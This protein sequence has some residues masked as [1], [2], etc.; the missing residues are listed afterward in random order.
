LRINVRSTAEF[1]KFAGKKI[2]S[3]L[4]KLEKKRKHLF[5]SQIVMAV[6]SILFFLGSFISF[7]LFIDDNRVNKLFFV[8]AFF[9]F[10]TSI[11][12][13]FTTKH[14]MDNYRKDYK[15]N[16]I[17]RI[18]SYISEN[19]DYYPHDHVPPVYFTMSGLLTKTP[20]RCQGEDLVKGKIEKTE[21][22]L[23]EIKAQFKH[24]RYHRHSLFMKGRKYKSYTTGFNGLFFVADFNKS[25]RENLVV[26]PDIAEKFFGNIV[27][28]GIQKFNFTRKNLIKLENI[29]FEKY[30]VVYGSDQI[31]SRYILTP[32]VMEN[33]VSLREELDKDIS[34][35]F[36]A[37]KMFVAIPYRK[38]LFEPS[39]FKSVVEKKDI[40]LYFDILN[41]MIGIV[42]RFELNKRIWE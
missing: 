7:F 14:S 12:F 5:N 19:L 25:F 28:T 11:Y 2:Y 17:N 37:N 24:E 38:N 35:S 33:I 29:K 42:E 30:F 22:M 23:S 32:D 20:D 39:Y 34:L 40:M 15:H 18:I 1:E 9:S 36:I 41:T 21:I 4:L 16:I 31:E 10:F 13:I 26:L 3:E 6:I 27:G 8:V